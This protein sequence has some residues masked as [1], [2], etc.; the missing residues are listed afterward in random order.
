MVCLHSS[1][2]LSSPPALWQTFDDL[3]GILRFFSHMLRWASACHLHG[4]ERGWHKLVLFTLMVEY[5]KQRKWKEGN[6]PS[7]TYTLSHPTFHIPQ[8]TEKHCTDL[9]EGGDRQFQAHW[10]SLVSV[11]RGLCHV[12]KV[13]FASSFFFFHKLHRPALTLPI[14]LFTWRAIS[15]LAIWNR[16]LSWL[17]WETVFIVSHKIKHFLLTATSGLSLPP[18]DC[19]QHSV[20]LIITLNHQSW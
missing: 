7:D 9:Q 11:D 1:A 2:F 4:V 20:N 3:P 15:F 5:S 8:Q 13:L 10:K 16:W 12:C 19:V 6:F 18:N 14:C 17:W